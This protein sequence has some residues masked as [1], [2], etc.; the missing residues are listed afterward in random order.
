MTNYKCY[1]CG[2][3]IALGLEL[4]FYPEEV[5]EECIKYL[6]ADCAEKRRIGQIQLP[7]A[8]D[9]DEHPRLLFNGEGISSGQTFMALLPDGWKRIRLEVNWNKTGA[10]CWYIATSGLVD[11]CPI[12]LFVKKIH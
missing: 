8:G 1:D 3:E 2:K 11:I 12:G 5:T 6:C 9:T 4:R 7:S 10:S